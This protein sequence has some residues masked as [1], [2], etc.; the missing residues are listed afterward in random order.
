VSKFYKFRQNNSGGSFIKPAVNVIIE[1][2][3]AKEANEI[4]LTKGVYFDES[5]DCYCCGSR[6]YEV[7]DQDGVTN[8]VDASFEQS[9]LL[10]GF[11]DDIPWEL[12][13]R[14]GES[15]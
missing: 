2:D 1:A 10:A 15:K 4:A 14:K 7:D 11:Y 9:K 5:R 3:S 6:W 8:L 12:V 13:V